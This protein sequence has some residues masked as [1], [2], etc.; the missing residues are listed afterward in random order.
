MPVRAPDPGPG[1]HCAGSGVL[2][3]PC[4]VARPL[5]GAGHRLFYASS[6]A[7]AAWSMAASD[8]RTWLRSV[9]YQKS[10]SDAFR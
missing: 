2:G 3:F 10:G 8:F 7:F 4:P 5:S 9:V 6:R 1:I